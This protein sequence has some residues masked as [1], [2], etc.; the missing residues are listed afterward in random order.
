MQ[1]I[2]REPST[3]PLLRIDPNFHTSEINNASIDNAERYLV[4]SG[5]NT[6]RVW[7]VRTGKLLQVMRPPTGTQN[8]N[9]VHASDISP[10][11]DFV[12]VAGSSWKKTPDLYIFERKSGKISRVIRNLPSIIRA[13][14]FSPDGKSIA[15]ATQG[16]HGIF[17]YSLPSGR[18][19]KNDSNFGIGRMSIKFSSDGKL[20]VGY[21]N[22]P[23]G[24]IR[25]YDNKLNL[26][27]QQSNINGKPISEMNVMSLS[28]SPDGREIALG[29]FF[30]INTNSMEVPILSSGDLSFIRIAKSGIVK[31]RGNLD[32][33]TWSS[34]G[35]RLYAGG[36]YSNN[37]GMPLLVF[38]QGGR[39]QI[40]T[41]NIAQNSLRELIP[42]KDG[43]VIYASSSPSLGRLS[44]QGKTIWNHVSPYLN[45]GT[46]DNRKRFAISADGLS[47]DV[48]Y[49]HEKKQGGKTRGM[50][51][52]NVQ[53]QNISTKPSKIR[54]YHALQPTKASGVDWNRADPSFK[55]RRLPIP[56]GD[57]AQSAAVSENKNNF[58]ISTYQGIYYFD[59][60]G[61]K[62]WYA[63]TRGRAMQTNISRDNR[64]LVSTVGDGT[65]RWYE[66]KTGKQRLALYVHPDKRRWVAWTP[67]GY[68]ASSPNSENLIGYH[69]NKSSSVAAEFID[70][71]Q[72]KRVYARA[73]LIGL[74]LNNDYN[75][76]E[77]MALKRT[78]DVR[79]QLAQKRLPPS[80]S[81]EGQQT[82]FKVTNRDFNLPILIQNRGSGIGRVEYRINGKVF[83]EAHARATPGHSP[84]GMIRTKRSF[85]LNDGRSI[86]E[87]I[88]FSKDNKMQSKSVKVI[89]DFDDKVNR[90][91]SLYIL[92]VGVTDYLDDSLDL[93]YAADDAQAFEQ[94]LKKH[95]GQAMYQRVISKV[96][97]DKQATLKGIR[98]EINKMSQQ[99][100]PQDVFVLF[101]AGHG[102]AID[103]RYHYIPHNLQY[104]GPEAVRRHS[105]NE[106]LLREWL[107]L[108]KAEKSLLVLDTCNA[109]QV[110]HKLATAR[111][112]S[113]EDKVAISN[114]MEST[115]FAVL[116]ASSST[117]QALA[118]VVN[119]RTKQGHG[120]FTNTVLNGLRGAADTS[121]D[122]RVSVRELESYIHLQVPRIS[123]QKWHF[124]QVPMSHVRGDDF[125]V[126]LRR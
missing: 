101:L 78:G 1:S 5:D 31:E 81:L 15:V 70:I 69:V 113:L 10:S 100:Q 29:S 7:D 64:W 109:G 80:I 13:L 124:R 57:W 52:W 118:G 84:P 106:D 51:S 43:G 98:N 120:L 75:R 96:L 121:R 119:Q 67:G 104:T 72:M 126:S 12:A 18:L 94:T 42:L 16:G 9:Y 74:A 28:F 87:A 36:M 110:I 60:N 4:T 26:L 123:Q 108:V 114:L 117:Q 125:M 82:T 35:T 63:S 19:I 107:S 50:F 37:A 59:K 54:T 93:K 65:I 20:L 112:A 95:T 22:Y 46:K 47:V 23:L 44:N 73:D 85:T 111:G 79:K 116:A 30:P 53:T 49:D 11:G 105:L 14:K 122:S 68:Y 58:A 38:G 32:Q 55:N 62:L 115:G 66:A 41:W 97:V 83:S 56:R 24:F 39:K 89:V 3:K 33:V 34:D 21:A 103:G 45:F 48:Y 86:I 76:A 102:M 2:A 77:N 6:A 91:P 71:S 90:L 40:A 92:S 88:A 99:A 8:T 27:K 25:L 61:K 17:L